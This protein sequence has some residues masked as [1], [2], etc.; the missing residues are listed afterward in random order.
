M[1]IDFCVP[2]IVWKSSHT[3]QGFKQKALQREK[4]KKTLPGLIW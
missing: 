2:S 1:F 4:E 3:F